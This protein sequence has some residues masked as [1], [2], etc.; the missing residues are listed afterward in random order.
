MT[1]VGPSSSSI[2]RRCWPRSD[3]VPSVSERF[4]RPGIRSVRR[5]VSKKYPNPC[6]TATCAISET[7]PRLRVA[8]FATRSV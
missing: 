5:W 4:M 1:N 2:S 3:G 7:R 8:V 6:L